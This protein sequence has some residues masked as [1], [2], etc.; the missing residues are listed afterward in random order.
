MVLPQAAGAFGFQDGER[1]LLVGMSGLRR[2]MILRE[3]L[4]SSPLTVASP[5][6]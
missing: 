6:R 3:C 1:T 4:P 5:N 2:I